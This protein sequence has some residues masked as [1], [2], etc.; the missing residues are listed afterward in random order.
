MGAR[1]SLRELMR[2]FQKAFISTVRELLINSRVF[3][4]GVIL[5]H[6]T[7]IHRL[8]GSIQ[9]TNEL[10]LQ[11]ITSADDVFFG[12]D[13]HTSQSA[14]NGQEGGAVGAPLEEG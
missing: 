2:R 13:G 8:E 7:V 11:F 4:A 5:R 3:G 10:I 1:W 12:D 6:H 9:L 14:S